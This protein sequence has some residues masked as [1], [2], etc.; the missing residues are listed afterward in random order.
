MSQIFA[1]KTVMASRYFHTLRHLKPVQFYGRLGH[2]FSQIKIDNTA[3]SKTRT[4]KGEWVLPARLSSSMLALADP[5]FRFRFL[6]QEHAVEC[7][8]DWNN[9]QVDKLWLYNLHYFDDLNAK[10]HS[11]RS[12]A[13]TLLVNR[14][15]NENPAPLG[16]GWEPYP[17]SLRIVNWVKWCLAGQAPEPHWLNSLALQTRVLMQRLE[18]H[19]LGNHLFAN[20]KALVFA[21][22][23]FEGNEPN[24]G[25]QRV[26]SC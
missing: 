22:L 10:N 23:F 5:S 2:K 8:K 3:A 7:S 16:N 14:W 25:W 9:P 20:A 18:H 13:H 6:N 26:L 24:N 21:G 19:L 4:T 1:S 12:A 11:V 17:T 15:I